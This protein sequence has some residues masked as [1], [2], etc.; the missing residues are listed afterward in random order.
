MTRNRLVVKTCSIRALF[1]LCAGARSGHFAAVSLIV[2]KLETSDDDGRFVGR[3]TILLVG[4]FFSYEM[5]P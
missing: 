2:H 5:R 1:H 3:V 4:F